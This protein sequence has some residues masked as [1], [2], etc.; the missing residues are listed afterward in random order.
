M[1]RVSYRTSWREQAELPKKRK[2][3]M[4]EIT[5]VINN[6]VGLHARPAALFVQTAN[7]FKSS[8]TA[9]NG[10]TTANA[11]SILNVLTLG[12]NKD[13]VITIT[14]E[15]EDAEQALQAFKELHANNFGEKE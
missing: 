5:L 1:A 10:S 7:K 4:P 15:G 3:I 8:I 11:K 12:A 9:K 13:S 6:K 14:A 2:I